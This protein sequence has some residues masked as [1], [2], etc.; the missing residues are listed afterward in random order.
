MTMEITGW[1]S[2]F[3]AL[4][5]AV[6]AGIGAMLG[7]AAPSA[8]VSVQRERAGYGSGP[9]HRTPYGGDGCGSKLARKAGEGK[10]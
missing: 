4:N 3:A 7:N 5:A 6:M 1:R 2:R 8:G 9:R 10:L